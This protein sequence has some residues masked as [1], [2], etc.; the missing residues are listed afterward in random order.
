M[1]Q[2]LA[3]QLSLRPPFNKSLSYTLQYGHGT[4]PTTK[5]SFEVPE[6]RLNMIWSV[7]EN[8]GLGVTS[9]QLMK[10]LLG[11]EP[12]TDSPAPET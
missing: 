6:S 4:S 3:I 11:I 10:T 9:E 1:V 8:G 7:F 5:L 2:P 12:P